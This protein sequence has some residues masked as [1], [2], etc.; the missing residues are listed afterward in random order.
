MS[1]GV[2]VEGRTTTSNAATGRSSPKDARFD[3]WFVV[4]V[5]TTGAF[6]AELPVQPIVRASFGSCR[7]RRLLS[8]TRNGAAPDAPAWVSGMECA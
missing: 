6:A 1:V 5:L 3:G 2:Y 4:V 7:P 8:R